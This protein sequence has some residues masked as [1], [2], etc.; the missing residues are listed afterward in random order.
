MEQALLLSATTAPSTSTNSS[1]R[2]NGTAV[3]VVSTNPTPTTTVPSSSVAVVD[4]PTVAKI[5]TSPPSL[6]TP[7]GLVIP[8]TRPP[9]PTPPLVST[10]TAT[11]HPGPT[12]Y[13]SDRVAA[14]E[15]AVLSEW[16]DGSA[17]HRTEASYIEARERILALA[18]TM[19]DQYVTGTMVRR[20]VA[21]DAGSLLRLHAFLTSHQMINRNAINESTPPPMLLLTAKPNRH[22]RAKI[23]TNDWD[24][25]MKWNVMQAVVEQSRTNRTPADHDPDWSAV[26]KSVGQGVTAAECEHLFRT[27]SIPTV[28]PKSD[29]HHPVVQ[30]GSITPDVVAS[31]STTGTD[32]ITTTTK[33]KMPPQDWIADL[34]NDVDPALRRAVTMAALSHTAGNNKN[35]LAQQQQQQQVPKAAVLGLMV[36]DAMDTA[37]EQEERVVEIL[38]EVMELRMQRI[39]SRL[40]TLDDVED[41]LEAER[42]ALE[43]ERRDLYTAR[44]RHWFGGT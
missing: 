16:F 12:W 43:L 41:M 8:L 11:I 7:T 33:S 26:A 29:H 9:C 40:S 18:T 1:S 21:G 24:D 38:S 14:L 23:S 39:E 4:A 25:V 42:V 35:D 28:H 22:K 2:T 30:D 44:C 36:R 34:V 27:M 10:T 3:V 20:T 17:A 15:R 19:P 5:V 6:P 31:V 32:P 13:Q 37:Q